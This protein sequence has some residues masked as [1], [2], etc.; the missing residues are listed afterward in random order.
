VL[1]YFHSLLDP[2]LAPARTC[3]MDFRQGLMPEFAANKNT[4]VLHL[5]ADTG[6]IWKKRLVEESFVALENVRVRMHVETWQA[7]E[8]YFSMVYDPARILPVTRAFSG[9]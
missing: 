4:L 1:G 9:P 5:M 3:E 7:F 2:I 8:Y 6:N